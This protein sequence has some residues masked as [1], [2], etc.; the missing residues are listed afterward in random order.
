VGLLT[1]GQRQQL[2]IIKLLVGGTRVLILD[3]PTTGITAAQADALFAALRTLTQEGKTVLFVSHKLAE[4]ESLCTSVSVLRA[5][6]VVGTQMAVPQPQSRLLSMMFGDRDQAP[7]Q[8]P[9]TLPPAP[10]PVTPPSATAPTPV[11]QLAG[12]SLRGGPLLLHDLNLSLAPGSITGLEGLEGSGQQLVLRALGGLLRPV[13]GRVHVAGS[14]MTGAPVADFLAADVQY[15]PADRMAD[16]VIWAFSLADHMALLAPKRGLLVDRAAATAAAEQAIA[17]Y[18]IKATPTTP[19]VALSGGNQQRAM[20][21]MLPN[22]CTGLLLEQPTRGLDVASAR[23]IWGRLQDR[24]TQGTA[25]V[26]ASADLDELLAYSDQ[27][28]VFFG[29]KVSPP[30]PRAELSES[31][32]AELIGGVGFVGMNDE[33]DSRKA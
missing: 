27:V 9:V 20:L 19:I 17:A 30:I 4:V 33:P 21:A 12:V 25:V 32:L 16:G 13:A 28:L 5:G 14:D 8:L 10:A 1:V 2:A 3:E 24:C 6:R 18:N 23:G 22:H 11:W 7:D 15:L 31:R 26:F 29:G